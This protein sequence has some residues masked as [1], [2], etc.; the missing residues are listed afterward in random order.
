MT[1]IIKPLSLS[2]V[3]ELSR[4]NLRESG[5]DAADYKLMRIE[6]LLAPPK[7][8][9]TQPGPGF[10]IPYFDIH[11]R[12]T[13]FFRYRYVQ[14]SP[15]GKPLRYVQPSGILP[16]VYWT[17]GTP[18][19]EILSSKLPLFI[20][21]G[22][23]KAACGCKHK[24]PTIGVG[25]VW[26]FKSR[27]L[28]LIEELENIAWADRAVYIVFDAD[29]VSNPSVMMAETR[30][31][32]ELLNRKALARS[33]RLPFET[34]GMDDFLVAYGKEEFQKLVDDAEEFCP[35]LHEMNNMVT[36]VRDPSGVWINSKR[37]LVSCRTFINE[38]FAPYS[39]IV[40]RSLPNGGQTPDV[41]RTAAEW[42]KWP[43]RQ[44][45]QSLV[46][47]PGKE[48]W[49]EG[50]LN[51]WNGWKVQPVKGD[52]KPW[53]KL[54]DFICAGMTPEQ[55]AWFEQWLAYPIQH[56]GAKL[57]SAVVIWCSVHGTGKTFIGHIM[58]EIYGD[59]FS[60]ISNDDLHSNF[61][62]WA[63]N[64][65]F[66]MGEEISGGE[67]KRMVNN[68]LKHMITQPSIL[69][70]TKYIPQYTLRD[71][72]NYYFTSNYP[73]AFYIEDTDRRFFIH[74][75]PYPPME[76]YKDIDMWKNSGGPSALLHYFLQVD[77]TGF[78]PLGPPPITLAKE[79]MRLDSQGE[80][81]EW[82]ARVLKAPDSLS[83]AGAPVNW[84]LATTRD[85]YNLFDP[86][87]HRRQIMQFSREL[88]KVRVPLLHGGK[89]IW[90]NKVP[91]RLWVLKDFERIN[92]MSPHQINEMYN[93]EHG[94]GRRNFDP[95]AM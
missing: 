40:M 81:Q 6:P 21:E 66:V 22:E 8:L 20:T 7:G 19:K 13:K 18:W 53:F 37:R 64:K 48:Q 57:F 15:F 73:D 9:T 41:K 76:S 17:P 27:A 28:K 39:H 10:R 5:L 46:Y 88:R 89:Q 44:Q 2:E 77:L 63:V 52:L 50:S 42:M 90:V 32:Q 54:F 33:I 55:K 26:S 79:N 29:S 45:A 16:Q 62:G 85:L 4:N 51:T 49:H 78:N 14:S 65:Q 24:F 60:E 87:N 59:N 43:G 93:R 86:E 56:P 70:N 84:S 69:V 23:K 74:E 82:A 75:T 94:D 12:V 30:L 68:R 38:D 61:N 47:E 34:K 58:R 92:M 11:G 91:V 95:G 80:T 3:D 36:Y 31:A 67:N 1:S 35:E 25:G 71:C 83:C 72:V